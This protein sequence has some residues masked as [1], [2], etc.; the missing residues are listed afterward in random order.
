[1]LASVMRD[2]LEHYEIPPDQIHSAEKSLSSTAFP[3]AEKQILASVLAV[4]RSPRATDFCQQAMTQGFYSIDT[5]AKYL[6]GHEESQETLYA[7]EQW[8]VVDL[9]M[10]LNVMRKSGFRDEA[11]K[12]TDETLKNLPSPAGN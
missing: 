9:A 8:R 2:A 7:I 10:A 3:A 11:D 6:R 1:M 5:L 4:A 12:I